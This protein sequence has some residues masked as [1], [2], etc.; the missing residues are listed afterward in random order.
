MHGAV[1]FCD[2][3][4]C[5]LRLLIMKH[6]IFVQK[7]S[8]VGT[9]DDGSRGC[10]LAVLIMG[11]S[12][13]SENT[14]SVWPSVR[15]P[16]KIAH[17]SERNIACRVHIFRYAH[18]VSHITVQGSPCLVLSE[19]ASTSSSSNNFEDK[20]FQLHP[21][22]TQDGNKHMEFHPVHPDSLRHSQLNQH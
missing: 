11:W 18:L 13:P 10:F 2:S 9:T 8:Q 21:Q 17:S 1:G 19:V 7:M 5:Q 16:V 14:A 22:T 4:G 6:V 20:T 12:H 3:R 15:Y